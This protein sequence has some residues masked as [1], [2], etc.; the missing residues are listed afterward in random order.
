MGSTVK[1]KVFAKALMGHPKG[2]PADHLAV[3]VKRV[4][5]HKTFGKAEVCDA[6]KRSV[7]LKCREK[8]TEENHL[9]WI[10]AKARNNMTAQGMQGEGRAVCKRLLHCSEKQGEGNN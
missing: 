4:V 8:I 6:Y 2:L 10:G 1:V 5:C 7:C 3:G 9:G